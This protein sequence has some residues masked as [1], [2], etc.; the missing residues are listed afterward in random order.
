MYTF[1]A[2]VLYYFADN[3]HI[4]QGFHETVMQSN[5]VIMCSNYNNSGIE[6][7]NSTGVVLKS[8]TL[9]NCGFNTF[10][11]SQIHP[12]NANISLLFTD[13]NNVTLERVSV[14]NGSDYGLWLVNSLMCQLLILH[15][16]TIW[17][18]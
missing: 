6:F 11:I 12:R 8:L 7:A 14:Q 4:S 16:P 3:A 13:T 9:A 1:F 18:S 15:L 5:S 10:I 2:C 17:M